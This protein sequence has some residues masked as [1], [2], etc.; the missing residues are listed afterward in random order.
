IAAPL[1]RA[2]V[3]VGDSRFLRGGVMPV[4][5]RPWTVRA[6]ACCAVAVTVL[7]CAGTEPQESVAKAET[8]ANSLQATRTE[9]AN[10]NSA[11]DKAVATLT[12]MTQKPQADLQPQFA[13][14]KD[15]VAALQTQA[16]TLGA[17]AQAMRARGEDYFKSWEQDL[18][19]INNPDLRQISADRRAK[20]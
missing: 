1:R 8:A 15:A 6:L 11:L 12:D 3:V 7:G 10:V 18:G 13:A 20:L 4:G 2:R 19:G 17:S 14:Y 16:K 5:T 9:I